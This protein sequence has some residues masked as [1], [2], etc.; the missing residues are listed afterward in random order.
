[1]RRRPQPTRIYQQVVKLEPDSKRIYLLL[2]LALAAWLR[3]WGMDYGLPHPLTRPDEER[4]VGRAQT[5]VATGNWHP[6]SFFYP[7]LPFYLNT[8]ALY[9][10]YG[11][12]KLT[13]SYDRLFDFLFDIAVTRPGLHYWICRWVSILVGVAT[14]AATYSLGRLAS[15]SRIVGIVAAIFLSVCH[16][17][18]RDSHFAT[19]DIV[20]TLFVT[21]S[22]LFA[23]RAVET[24]THWSYA[25]AG[26]ATGLATSS[27]YNAA[28]VF[29]AIAA[30]ALVGRRD[31]VTT[32]KHLGIAAL[33]AAFVFSP[34]RPTCSS[35]TEVSSPT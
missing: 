5:I 24:P 8:F 28:I 2:A 17:H 25:L 4:L 27:K 35:V 22:L 26:L 10:Y 13:G 16:L 21:I 34:R 32:A 23:L 30:A 20:M 19:V 31:V 33:S 12:G 29:V 6:G 1:M 9:L 14:V 3:V 18:V 15:G 11:I 7:S